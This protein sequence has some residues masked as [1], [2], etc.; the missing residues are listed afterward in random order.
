MAHHLQNIVD[1]VIHVPGDGGK[2]TQDAASL[3]DKCRHR[4][5]WEIPAN[6]CECAQSLASRVIYTSV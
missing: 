6:L 3:K 1:G 2:R 4:E 5:T